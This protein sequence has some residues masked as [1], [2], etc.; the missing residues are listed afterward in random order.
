MAATSSAGSGL[1]F[2]VNITGGQI[3]A[4]FI[5]FNQHGTGYTDGQ[6]VNLN[7]SGGTGAQVRVYTQPEDGWKAVLLGGWSQVNPDD[8]WTKTLALTGFDDGSS[9]T[10]ALT[11]IATQTASAPNSLTGSAASVSTT[12]GSISLLSGG[13][14]LQ[15]S[16]ASVSTTTGAISLIRSLR[17]SAASVSLTTGNIILSKPNSLQ[18][19]ALSTSRT[20]ATGLR[21]V[22]FNL[23]GSALS[24][25]RTSG[26]LVLE[27]D[28][29]GTIPTEPDVPPGPPQPGVDPHQFLLG[30]IQSGLGHYKL[31]PDQLAEIYA[32]HL[33]G[34][35][36]KDMA[37]EF[38]LPQSV[39]RKLISRLRLTDYST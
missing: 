26:L 18:G 36:F 8:A 9:K 1:V 19:S 4:P 12:T 32:R 31:T 23:R 35:R 13:K 2:N 28:L 38:G 10:Q 34:E 14:T 21:I 15:G 39:M 30:V 16:A 24:I 37:V 27:P 6:I 11:H 3:I 22:L 25:S 7:G 5:V 29:P 33:E 20:T 17:G